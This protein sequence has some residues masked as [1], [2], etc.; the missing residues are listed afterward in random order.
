LLLVVQVFS[1]PLRS[2][3][4]SQEPVR[5]IDWNALVVEHTV[6]NPIDFDQVDWL[7][8]LIKEVSD[9]RALALLVLV[10]V[11]FFFVAIIRA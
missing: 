5:V 7:A 8:L 4:S 6:S 10:L 1:F 3:A 11:L 9:L 2:R